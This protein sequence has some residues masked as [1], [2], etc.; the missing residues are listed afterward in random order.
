MAKRGRTPKAGWKQWTADE[1]RAALKAWR[2][3]GLSRSAF[4]EKAGM[5]P[6]RLSW[7]QRRLGDWA[8]EAPA[9]LER[10]LRL[11]PLITTEAV[12]GEVVVSPPPTASA[13][14]M[15]LPGG[16]ALEFDVAQMPAA[17]VAAVALEVAR[18]R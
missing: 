10:A 7:W 11:V 1:A 6:Q 16:V 5:T 12:T 9:S 4:A 17:W 14:T 8:A 18:A 15:R 3:S 13:T 2:Q